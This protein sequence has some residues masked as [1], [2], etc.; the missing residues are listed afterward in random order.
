MK[1]V[2]SILLVLFVVFALA[3]SSCDKP[4]SPTTPDIT[5]SDK[6][7]VGDSVGLA[8]ELSQDEQSYTLIGIGEFDGDV[9]VIP[10]VHE[11]K[12]VSAIASEAFQFNDAIVELYIPDSITEIGD[13]AFGWCSALK[14]IR[15]GAGIRHIPKFAF[16]YTSVET[17]VIPDT[18]TS[19]DYAAFW[20]CSSL[21]SIKLG[22]G[23]TKLGAYYDPFAGE[24][25]FGGYTDFS[26]CTSLV[27]ILVEE[28]HPTFKS[29]DGNLYSKDGSTIVKYAPGKKDTTFTF[30]EHLSVIDKGAFYNADYLT[31]VSIPN[32]VSKVSNWAFDNCSSI[33]TVF[34]SENVNNIERWVFANCTSLTSIE[35]EENNASYKSVDG[36]L[37]SKDGTVLMQYTAGSNA[38]EFN[39]PAGVINIGTASFSGAENLVKVVLPEGVETIEFNAFYGCK[40]LE[41][42]YLP[43]TL[44]NIKMGGFQE[45]KALKTIVYNG[46]VKEWKNVELEFGWDSL[47]SGYSIRCTDDTIIT[48]D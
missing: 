48:L 32:S 16:S 2:L 30:P 10:S 38:E 39:V 31:S 4:A 6:P 11:G 14:K 27:S 36:N 34:I 9:L 13:S 29:I 1:K 37:Y 46:T 17:V 40:A 24:I 23:V 8:Y 43:S 42:I 45:C 35:V 3:L 33:V 47:I 20:D 15:I 21:T 44:T 18:V 22:K 7:A 28:D 19:V 26:N 25:T 41:E 5:E 12:P